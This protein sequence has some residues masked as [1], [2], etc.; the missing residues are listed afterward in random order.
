MQWWSQYTKKNLL[1]N[2][3]LKK[4]EEVEKI[5]KSDQLIVNQSKRSINYQ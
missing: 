3:L 2:I 4:R 1:L 5:E